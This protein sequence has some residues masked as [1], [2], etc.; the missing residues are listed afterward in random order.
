MRVS[1]SLPPRV[2]PFGWLQQKGFTLIELLV[3]IGIIGLLA[4]LLLPVLARTKTKAHSISCLSNTQQLGLAWLLYSDD[5]NGRLAYNLGGDVRGRGVAP[6]NNLNWVNNILD[7]E[8][9]RDNT[10]VNTIKESSL[11][12]Y[13]NK[14]VMIYRCPADKVLSQI[15]RRAGW[16]ARVRSYS[17]NAMVGDA[18]D[19][20]Q[21]GRNRNN[22]E[23]VQFFNIASIPQPAGIFVFLDEH[24]DS[25]NDGYFI[26]KAYDWTWVDLPA[27]YHN[28]A[29]NFSF[30]DGHAESH[31]WRL[32]TTRRPARPDGAPLPMKL[33]KSEWGDYDWV[34]KRMS[35]DR[36]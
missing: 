16:S 27:S 1:L 30:A 21:T 14:S 11:G 19:L 17:M 2:K 6:H 24:P 31:Y 28:G 25:I 36:D 8:L 22:P 18:G 7:W 13:G 15:Q 29:G 32:E 4:S 12:P 9:T 5:H 26:N 20:S 35:V 10:N 33:T 34:L 23:Y 3:V